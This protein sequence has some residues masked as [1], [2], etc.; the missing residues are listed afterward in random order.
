MR[1]IEEPRCTNVLDDAERRV[2]RGFTGP[3]AADRR[4]F[5][6]LHQPFVAVDHPLPELGFE[7]IHWALSRGGATVQDRKTR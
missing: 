7:L 6:V 5:G 1:G 2:D 4:A 3:Q